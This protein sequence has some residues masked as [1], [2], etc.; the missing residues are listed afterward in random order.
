MLLIFLWSC[1]T[2]TGADPK[3]PEG[4][5]VPTLLGE[6]AGVAFEGNWT[7]PSCGGR[8]YAR[9]IRFEVDGSY[10]T[11]DLVSPC[12]PGTHCVWSGMVG[13][14]G[15]WVLS[16]PKI[17]SLREIGAP[18]GP[19]SPHPSQFTADMKGNLIESTCIYQKG[20]TI[21][22]GY[23]E[24]QVTPRVPSVPITGTDAPA[25]TTP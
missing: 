6:A 21:P 17:L 1:T 3:P 20:L 19:G 10:A 13:Y 14:G 12:P 18:A 9:N 2:L 22:P 4:P 11:I 5:T 15:T 8:A 23:T 24:E 7:S 25:P 16:D